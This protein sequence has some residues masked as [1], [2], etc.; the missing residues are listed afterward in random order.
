MFKYKVMGD[1]SSHIIKPIILELS[2]QGA[3]T[4]TQIS[5]VSNIPHSTVKHAVNRLVKKGLIT[6]TGKG[7]RW[8]YVYSEPIHA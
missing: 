1:Y 2:E 6:R 8:G 3:V 5:K 4:Y 7:R